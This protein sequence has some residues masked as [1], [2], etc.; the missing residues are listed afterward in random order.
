VG[1]TRLALL[2]LCV[3]LSICAC[4]PATSEPAP[5]APPMAAV[6]PALEPWLRSRLEAYRS[7]TGVP[8]FD[9]D[10]MPWQTAQQ[11]IRRGEVSLAIMAATPP[12]DWFATPLGVEPLALVVHPGNRLPGITRQQAEG[13]LSGEITS[14]S[15]LGMDSPDGVQIYL[16]FP[17]DDVRQI[18]SDQV[19]QG[20][21]FT[22]TARLFADPARAV[23]WM[24]NDPGAL[25]L[26][27]LSAVTS[28][29]RPLRID[30]RLPSEALEADGSYPLVATVL[31]TAPDEPVGGL[32]QFLGWLQSLLKP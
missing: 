12:S 18:L 7:E 27:P 16:P 21:R 15:G 28:A 5:P 13:L 8:E 26:V 2:A 29:V 11:N 22:S 25:G 9:L 4:T 24:A 31:A 19:M 23:D 32:R 17:G 14:W 3:G 10:V 6:S 1:S 20:R 30:G